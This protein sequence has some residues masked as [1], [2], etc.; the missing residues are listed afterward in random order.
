[1]QDGG[2]NLDGLLAATR[3]QAHAPHANGTR[4]HVARAFAAGMLPEPSPRPDR[5][6]CGLAP[7]CADW[8]NK[9]RVAFHR[10]CLPLLLTLIDTNHPNSAD[11][12]SAFLASALPLNPNR[13]RISGNSLGILF[14]STK[15]LSCSLNW[16]FFTYPFHTDLSRNLD[17]R[18]AAHLFLSFLSLSPPSPT[19]AG[20]G[21]HQNV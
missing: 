16:S 20:A 2:I 8:L 13:Q 1:M 15:S 7:I 11:P 6:G 10:A 19:L 17:N 9:L 12:D 18:E 14:W 4:A 3:S 5:P 21:I